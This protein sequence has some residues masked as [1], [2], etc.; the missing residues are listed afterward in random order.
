VGFRIEHPQELINEIQYHRWASE[1]QRGKGR[2]PVADYKVAADVDL[3]EL[4]ISSDAEEHLHKGCYSF[5]MC[6]G[7]QV[8]YPLGYTSPEC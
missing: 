7:G 5:C 2:V 6:P 3:N 1:V 8:S 4:N